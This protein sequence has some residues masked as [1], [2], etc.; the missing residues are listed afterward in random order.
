[1]MKKK[2]NL[3]KINSHFSNFAKCLLAHRFLF[4]LA[5]IALLLLSFAGI[6]RIHFETSWDS[7]FME[8]D[9]VLI[10]TDKFKEIFGNDYYAAVLTECDN[11]FTTENLSLIR[12]LSNELRDSLTYSDNEAT[13]LADVEFSLGTE[14][15]MEIIQLVPEE[16]P[17]DAAGLDS[18]RSRTFSKPELARQLVS[19]DGR[20][21][22]ILIKLKKFPEASEWKAQ[23]LKAP[24]MQTGA[25]LVRIISKEKYASLNPKGSGMPFV[26]YCKSQYIGQEMG[27][28][29]VIAIIIAIIVMALVTRSLRGVIAPL[30]TTVSGIIMTFGLVGFIGLYMDTSMTMVPIILAFA[31]SIAY[32]IHLN[33]HFRKEMYKHGKRK[34]AV[35]NT[36]HETGWSIL[37]SGLTTICALLSFLVIHLK[38][39]RYIGIHS[40]IA[41]S[42]ILL[43]ALVIS[44]ILLSFGKD[45]KPNPKL[46][47]NKGETRFSLI[48]E[49]MGNFALNHKLPI[50]LIFA[51]LAVIGIFGARSVEPTFE[52]EKTMGRK[53]PYVNEIVTVAE[54]EIGTLYSYDLMMEFSDGDAKKAETLKKFDSIST[55]AS[56]FPLS[57]RIYSILDIIKDL[58]RTINGNDSAFYK[59]PDEDDQVAQLLL[60]YENAGGSK[61][62][63]WID[64]DYK[65]LRLNIQISKYDSKEVEAE[66]D[67][68]TAIARKVFPNAKVSP[69]G[70]L[71]QF[72]T[73]QQ[74]VVMGEVQSLLVS[75]F[76]IC[77]LLS[78]V[79]LNIRTG[80]I[81]M[82]PN[83]TPAIFVGGYMGLSGIPL[84]MMLATVIPMLIG[85]SVDDTIHIV[86]HG[87]EEFDRTGNYRQ[88]ILATFRK[89]G[90]ALVLTTVIMSSIFAT[91]C[92]SVCEEMINFGLLAVIGMMSALASDLF[93]TPILFRTFK[94]FGKETCK[95]K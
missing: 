87:R 18:I 28:I 58:N 33:T 15:G 77:L 2:L 70:N 8:G 1:M 12:E 47:N 19:K 30:L 23:N 26:S 11:S 6:K 88:A 76:I 51:I 75:A 3:E 72:T 14:E 59:I 68:I 69:V 20:F 66:I 57:K 45:K 13:S 73:M 39:I 46:L 22:W 94:I 52:V 62:E 16:I 92:T 63:Q 5:F 83:L 48:M 60:L 95:D 29:M 85:L 55:I 81:C 25:E 67:S 35:I 42:F 78:I 64:Y 31:V 71:P 89:T 79:F 40:S 90:Q 80:L 10:Q 56:D 74:Y 44:P 49:S 24:D 43:I 32:N 54:S 38:P 36:I 61:A 86:N 65:Y 50:L 27:R 82:I 9:P 4:I 41:I 84:D 7:Y 53:V 91:F 21:S 37:F 93:V 17:T 34:E